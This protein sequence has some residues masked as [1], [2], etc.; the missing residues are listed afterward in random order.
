[1]NWVFEWQKITLM[2]TNGEEAR[3]RESLQ[4]HALRQYVMRIEIWFGQILYILDIQDVTIV[5]SQRNQVG[6]IPSVERLAKKQYYNEYADEDGNY[7]DIDERA[8][9]DKFDHARVGSQRGRLE[10]C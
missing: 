10:D 9:N 6:R 7:E 4:Q 1:M 8:S 3:T 2:A 5:G